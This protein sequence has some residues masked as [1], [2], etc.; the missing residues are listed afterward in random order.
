M[1]D[2]R[3]P[4][5]GL[6]RTSPKGGPF[7]GRCIY[8]R[9]EGLPMG[10]ALQPCPDAPTLDQQIIDAIEGPVMTPRCSV[11]GTTR[12]S[13]FRAS[14]PRRCKK[15]RRAYNAQRKRELRAEGQ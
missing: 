9:A 3:R 2:T 8:C 7:V 5:H 10:A 4:T 12:R 6:E 1:T 14:E 11:C 15:C 13:R